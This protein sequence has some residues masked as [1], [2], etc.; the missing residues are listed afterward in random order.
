MTQE[1]RDAHIKQ[2]QRDITSGNTFAITCLNFLAK[3]GSGEDTR[4]D[5][6]YI[7][8]SLIMHGWL[9]VNDSNEFILK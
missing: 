5:W 2:L 6:N 9:S 7:G 3:H 4:R 8:H 1:T